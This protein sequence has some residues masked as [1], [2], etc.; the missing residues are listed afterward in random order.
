MCQSCVGRFLGVLVE[1]M[2]IVN[3]FSFCYEEEECVSLYPND[4]FCV[5]FCY[6]YDWLLVREQQMKGFLNALS[7]YQLLI[8]KFPLR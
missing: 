8:D 7:K 3:S 4:V 5:G 2:N 1:P 6:F